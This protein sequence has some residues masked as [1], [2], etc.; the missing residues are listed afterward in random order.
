[1]AFM[2]CIALTSLSANEENLRLLL[3]SDFNVAIFLALAW[4][5]ERRRVQ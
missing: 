2:I 5:L 3:I 1:M 4:F